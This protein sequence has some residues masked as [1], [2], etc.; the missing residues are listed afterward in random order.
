MKAL[1]LI[2]LFVSLGGCVSSIPVKEFH[3]RPLRSMSDIDSQTAV[4]LVGAIGSETI[5]YIQLCSKSTS[6]LNYKNISL[7]NDV[8]AL[9]VPVPIKGLELN[10]YTVSS[11]R[12]FYFGVQP[13]GYIG[14]NRERINIDEPCAFYLLTIHT[15]EK[16]GYDLAPS[17]RMLNMAKEK[18]GSLPSKMK[19]LNFSWP[20]T[21]SQQPKPT[22]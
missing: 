4:V 7:H 13:V 17:I 20:S 21:A 22:P 9:P 16:G 3:E 1:S 10:S 19:A 6:C 14:V 8:I 18:Y 12:A 5:N 15:D 11:R 2:M